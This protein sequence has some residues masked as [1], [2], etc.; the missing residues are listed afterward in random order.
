M[1]HDPSTISTREV[2]R[3]LKKMPNIKTDSLETSSDSKLPDDTKSVTNNLQ[4]TMG[5]SNE[6][7][8]LI[9]EKYSL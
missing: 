1:W 3:E 4:D 7:N 5:S 9:N 8:L 6:D 2:E